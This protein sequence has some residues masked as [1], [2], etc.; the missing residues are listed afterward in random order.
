M[1]GRRVLATGKGR[2]PMLYKLGRLLQLIGLILLPI[3]MAGN[4]AEKMSEADM[5]KVVG[6]GIVV[7]LVGWLLQRAAKPR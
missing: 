3:A 2:L 4:L 1:H 7:F 5:L 6:A